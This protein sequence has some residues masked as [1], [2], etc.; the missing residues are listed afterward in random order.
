[1]GFELGFLTVQKY[2]FSGRKD[3]LIGLKEFKICLYQ[4]LL[5]IYHCNLREK[6]KVRLIQCYYMISWLS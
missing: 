1:M 4:D 6:V 3:Y 5:K 2:F